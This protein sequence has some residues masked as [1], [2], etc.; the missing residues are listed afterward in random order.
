MVVVYKISESG[1]GGIVYIILKK[2]ICFDQGR[3][4][5]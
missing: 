1:L 4:Y 2:F 5:F 3:F